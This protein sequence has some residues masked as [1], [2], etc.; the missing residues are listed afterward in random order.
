MPVVV[1]QSC[2]QHRLFCYCDGCGSAWATPHETRFEAG[3]NDITSPAVFAPGGAQL[4]S[5]DVVMA[6]G[7]LSHVVAELDDAWLDLQQVN[8]TVLQTAAEVT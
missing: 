4:P 5:Q 6:A 3:L 1:L 8:A 7:W 2:D